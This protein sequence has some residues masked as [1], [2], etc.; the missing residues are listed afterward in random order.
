MRDRASYRSREMSSRCCTCSRYH[1]GVR[2]LRRIIFNALAALSF[3]FFL[4]TLALWMR[5][6]WSIDGIFI[7]RGPRDCW[8]VKSCPSA[9]Y[10]GTIDG[11]VIALR[12]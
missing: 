8:V 7:W 5:S 12:P 11:H 10:V 9:L 2:G 4:A 3:F 6:Y 1:A